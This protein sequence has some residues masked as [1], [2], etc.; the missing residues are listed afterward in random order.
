MFGGEKVGEGI[1]RTRKD[2]KYNAAESA[3]LFLASEYF[4]ETISQT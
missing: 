3:L 1:G 4:L 2:A